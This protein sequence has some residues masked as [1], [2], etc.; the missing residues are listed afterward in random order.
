MNEEGNERYWDDAYRRHGGALLGYLRRLSRDGALAEE[1][2]QETFER[3]LHSPRRVPAAELRPWLYR[4]AT[5]LV[6][7]SARRRKRLAFV[8]FTGR[9]TAVTLDLEG[10]ELVRRALQRIPTDQATALVLRLH[11][12][13]SRAE[14]CAIVGVTDEALKSR[15]TRGRRNFIE[16]YR[17]LERGLS[18]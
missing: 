6:V 15:L 12:G 10:A 8:P 9:E 7:D 1:H 16:V 17:R 14:I 5:N 2:L 4:I 3:A 13:F 11:E 18:G